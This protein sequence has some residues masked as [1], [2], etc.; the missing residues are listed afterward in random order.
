MNFV[1][2]ASFTT[3]FFFLDNI[4]LPAVNDWHP[5]GDNTPSI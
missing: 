4:E 5:F 2:F 1:F 3:F